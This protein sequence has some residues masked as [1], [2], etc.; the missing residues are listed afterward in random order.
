[1]RCGGM[2]ENSRF[3]VVYDEFLITICSILDDVC[4]ELADGGT[5]YGYTDDEEMAQ[6]MMLECFQSLAAKNR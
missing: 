6:R 1:M 5:I 2:S 3:Y 4:E